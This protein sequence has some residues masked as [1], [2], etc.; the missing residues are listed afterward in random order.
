MKKIFYLLIIILSL[1]DTKVD[2]KETAEFIHFLTDKIYDECIGQKILL[3]NDI[4]IVTDTQQPVKEIPNDKEYIIKALLVLD[5]SGPFK[6]YTA[7]TA[8]GQSNRDGEGVL[9]CGTHTLDINF[10]TYLWDKIKV[11]IP[12]KQIAIAGNVSVAGDSV[13]LNDDSSYS[14]AAGN[15]S[16]AISGKE[17][18]N[19]QPTINTNFNFK[20]AFNVSLALNLTLALY[21][22]LSRKTKKV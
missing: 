3:H 2:A 1:V 11:A 6:S 14:K 9:T 19:S 7:T 13:T 17:N 22:M 8:I 5:N 20:I 4:V 21:L 12:T 15:N 10:D 18:T 16:P